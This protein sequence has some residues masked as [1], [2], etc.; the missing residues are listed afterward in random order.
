[1]DGQRR[2][3]WDE[4]PDTRRAAPRDDASDGSATEPI[5]DLQARAGNR[6]VSELLAA[7]AVST[8]QREAPNAPPVG[9]PADSGNAAGRAISI[10]E[11]KLN[12][13]IESASIGNSGPI[14]PGELP[15]D[16]SVTFAASQADAR[17]VHAASTGSQFGTVVITLGPTK[18]TLHGATITAFSMSSGSMVL[19]LNAAS[20]DVSRELSGG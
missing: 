10:P 9:D 6:A 1:M 19:Q 12:L 3:R 18:L 14:R 15:R 4:E 7:G 8:V 17:L 13:P 11:L 5:L 2:R 16:V 20:V